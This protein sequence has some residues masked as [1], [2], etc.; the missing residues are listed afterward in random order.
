MSPVKWQPLCHSLNVLMK[1]CKKALTPSSQTVV[2][3]H[4]Y[5]PMTVSY[6][7]SPRL[8]ITGPPLVSRPWDS[9][10]LPS[11]S[12]GLSLSE[13]PPVRI[14]GSER[15]TLRA[16]RPATWAGPGRPDRLPMLDPA[17]VTGVRR[18][19]KSAMVPYMEPEREAANIIIHNND[20]GRIAKQG[21]YLL[22]RRTSYSKILWSLEAV[23]FRFKLFQS[24]WNLTGTSVA[25]LP[26]CLSSFNAIW[27]L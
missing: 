10:V 15:A 1:W 2:L 24:L 25:P 20:R 6:L 12:W 18:S 8:N 14:N 13:P 5:H 23:R 11:E 4:C 17:G 7:L 19:R 22:S 9:P 21:L 26:R 3:S 16:L 27:S